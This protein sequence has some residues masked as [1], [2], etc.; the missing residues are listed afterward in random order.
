MLKAGGMSRLTRRTGVAVA[1]DLG[2]L[3]VDAVLGA[4]LLWEFRTSG[5]D[6]KWLPAVPWNWVPWN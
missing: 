5:L 4:R 1:M 6:W 2:V 3:T